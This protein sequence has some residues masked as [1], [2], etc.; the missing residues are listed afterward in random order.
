MRKAWIFVGLLVSIPAL[1]SKFL[2]IAP[3]GSSRETSDPR[4]CRTMIALPDETPAASARA[5]PVVTAPP[6][7]RQKT[8]GR[9]TNPA[10]LK[11]ESEVSRDI[12]ASL[13]QKYKGSYSLQETLYNGHMD[14]YRNICRMQITPE[15]VP[16]L[17]RLYQNYYPRYSLIWTLIQQEQKAY[18]RLR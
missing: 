15:L 1:A 3:D 7:A 2:C 5:A 13:A 14:G 4:G 11:S 10:C 17:E 18:W 16:T 12:K 9:I 8:S 6:P